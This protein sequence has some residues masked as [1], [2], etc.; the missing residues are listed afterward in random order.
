[1]ENSKH[2][3]NYIVNDVHINQNERKT[4][5]VVMLT[6]CMMVIEIIAGY[7]TGSMALLADGWHMASHATALGISVLT[8]KLAKSQK[9]QDSFTFGAGKFIPL[10]GYTSTIFLAL[11][12]FFMAYESLH[13]LIYP[14]TIY[15]NEAIIVAIIGLFI[16]LISA[17]ILKDNHHH[18]EHG[19]HHQHNHDHNLKAAYFHV[20]ADAL[21]SLLAIVA[22]FYGK[23]FNSVWMDAVIGI[24]GSL[25]I[26]KWAYG[27][28]KETAW[29]LLDGNAKAFDKD[30]IIAKLEEKNCKVQDFHI[31]RIAPSAHACELVVLS[32]INKGPEYYKN[33]LI[34]EYGLNHIVVEE[35]L[36]KIS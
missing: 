17:L 13:R 28:F 23:Y 12:A 3:H 20:L 8:Y 34:T 22:L 30:E 15:F 2:T 29:E 33:I 5:L 9:L 25:V 35:T 19:E 26:L 18:H 14:K 7:L 6:A 11:M 10:G 32:S 1:M 31:W 21:T 24:V 4:F 16:N 27:L 36:S